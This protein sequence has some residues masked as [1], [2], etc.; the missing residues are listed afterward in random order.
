MRRFGC[1]PDK[2]S[3]GPARPSHVLQLHGCQWPSVSPHWRPLNSP[4]PTSASTQGT[5]ALSSGPVGSGR[6]LRRQHDR[7]T[8][9][10]GPDRRRSFRRLLETLVYIGRPRYL[11]AG[12]A[13]RYLR[14]PRS[15]RYPLS[16]GAAVRLALVCQADC[17]NFVSRQCAYRG[18]RGSAG[19]CG[20][21]PTRWSVRGWG[22]VGA[23]DPGD[24]VAVGEHA[25]EG[26]ERRRCEW[27]EDV[28]G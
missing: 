5:I 22:G 1:S 2:C 13:P 10:F 26:S 19:R 11:T 6:L 27:D 28:V 21:R 20:P 17:R 4:R 16:L 18:D 24:V 25:V 9:G 3:S 23:D 8:P 15:T 12:R 7:D 14:C